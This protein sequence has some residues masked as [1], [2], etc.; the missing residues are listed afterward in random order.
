MKYW[1]NLNILKYNNLVDEIWA[2]LNITSRG[3][4]SILFT[5]AYVNKVEAEVPHFAAEAQ[6][7]AKQG[8][9]QKAQTILTKKKLAEKE[10]SYGIKF[11]EHY[12]HWH[13]ER[14]KMRGLWYVPSKLKWYCK[15]I[16]GLPAAAEWSKASDLEVSP[17]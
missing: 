5:A 7:L 9:I 14:D 3:W 12:M 6:Q 13:C 1:W 15:N 8:D 10:V 16:V 11:C 17:W 4:I 2:F